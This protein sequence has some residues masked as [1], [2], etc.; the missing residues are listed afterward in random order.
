MERSALQGLAAA[1]ALALGLGALGV[2]SHGRDDAAVPVMV[3]GDPQ[4]DACAT[5]IARGERVVVRSGPSDDHEPVDALDPGTP[6]SVCGASAERAWRAVVYRAPDQ[7]AVDCGVAT[8]V[9]NATRYAGPCR[10]G[11]V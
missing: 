10:Y 4:L 7:T 9:A 1:G 5:G 11:W 6:L 8:P 3:G 2:W